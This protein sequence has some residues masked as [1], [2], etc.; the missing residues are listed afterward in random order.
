MHPK[1]N[2]NTY[3][4]A[5]IMSV[6]VLGFHMFGASDSKPLEQLVKLFAVRSSGEEESMPPSCQKQPGKL[7]CHLQYHDSS[8]LFLFARLSPQHYYQDP[9]IY[10]FLIDCLLFNLLIVLFC[11]IPCNRFY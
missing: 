2:I 8:P 6:P 9:R 5:V 10:S 1:T 4:H 7:A 3:A 11:K